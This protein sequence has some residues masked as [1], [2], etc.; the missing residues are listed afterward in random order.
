MASLSQRSVKNYFT[1]VLK[2]SVASSSQPNQEANANHSEVPLPSSQEFDLST[3]NYDPGERTPILDYHP[4]HRDVIRRACLINGPCQP[5]LLQHEYP[6]TN[7]SGS[8][9]RFNSEWF[10]DVYHDWLE[11]SVSKDTVYCLYCYLFKG[12][13]TNQGG[14]EIFSTVGFK[15]WQ[16]KKNL[17]KH[18]GLPN[19]PHNQSKKKC[20]D[21]L[22]VQQSIHFALEMQFSQFKHVYLVRLSASVDV[23]RLLITQGLTFQ[24]HNESKSSLSRGNFLQISHDIVSACKIET[25]K[26]IL[27]E[28]NGD[29]FSLLVDE[30]FDVS[31]KDQMAIVLRYIDRNGFVME[32]LFDIVHVQDTSAL[33]L[34][35][36]I[37]Q[38]LANAMLL[39]EVAK[40]RLQAYRDEEWG[41]LIARVSLFCIKHEILVP[42]FEESYVSSL[43]SRRRLDDNK[44]SHHY[45]VE[46]F[47][48][49]IDWQLQELKDRFGEATTDLL[50]GISCLNPIDL[51]SS[52]DIRKIMKMAKLHPD[53]FNEFNMG[54]LENQLAGYI[55]DVRDVDE[56]FSNLK[57][58]CDLSK[59]LVQTKKHSNYPLV[60]RLVKL[61]LLLPVATASVERAF[62][63]MKFIKNDLRSQMSDDFFSGCLVPYLE[64]DVF[65]NVS[66]DAIIN[67]F[68]DMKPRRVLL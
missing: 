66:N 32:R 54:S 10:D 19:S 43:R 11:F 16:K 34:K 26:A 18:I 50:H 4:N 56:R 31:R 62:S 51:F 6:Q 65:D 60:F 13:N 57:G 29:Y 49:I 20:Q 23:V 46:V 58:L 22:R 45:H 61:A 33:S 41:S 42:N 7:I 55:I 9:R 39:V 40:I 25:I 59:K 24:G 38:D 36:A 8:M 64:K 30:S 2:S 53:D 27:G 5:Q 37:E 14:G 44:V 15:S 17:G 48:N 47:C 35:R 67:T 63:A 28:L 12:Y 68:Q 21:L 1:K 3:L 52:V